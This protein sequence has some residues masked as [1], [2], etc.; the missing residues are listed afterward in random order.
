[1]FDYKFITLLG[2][3][4][5]FAAISVP[6]LFHPGL[7]PVLYPLYGILFLWSDFRH[8]TESHI[9]FL[10]L[11]TT[12]GFVLAGWGTPVQDRPLI[13]IETLSLWLLNWGIG[14][15]NGRAQADRRETRGQSAALENEMRDNEREVKYYQSYQE[16]VETQIRLRRDLTECAKSLGNT[17]DSREVH[18]RLVNILT[19]RYPGC[20]VQM[21][22]GAT[23]DPL[24]ALALQAHGPVLVKDSS[25]DSRFGHTGGVPFRSAMAVPLRVM[26]RSAGF[27][28]L[29]SDAPGAFGAED[30]KT[31]DLFGTMASLSL[32]NIQF[33]ENVHDQATHDTLTQLYSHKAFQTRLKEELLRAGRSQTPLSFILCD[34]DH[35]K[36]YN[37]RYGHQAG[38]QLLRVLAGILTS[39]ARP[40]D[41][42]ARYGGEEFCLIVPN[43]VRSEAVDLANRIRLRVEAEAFVFQGQKTSATMSVGVANFPQDATTPSQIIRVA[44][45]RLYRAKEN[46]RNQVVG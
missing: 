46:G 18:M 37:D 17:L 20:R 30:V 41:F 45:E 19:A 26:R 2:S 13:L 44:D 40:V 5:L 31:I 4:I 24:L 43:F 14:L 15:H 35:F 28:K 34:V 32:E 8:E 11:V 39:F 36:S 33:Y 42:A 6:L 1:M 12:V 16:N 9:I 3:D 22:A 10:F 29:E 25:T 7:G 38:D 21:V 27:V 23:T